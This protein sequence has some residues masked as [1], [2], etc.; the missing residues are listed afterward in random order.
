M[1]LDP[2]PIKLTQVDVTA[3]H[4][5]QD[6]APL[7]VVGGLP[8]ATTLTAGG[9]KKLPAQ[10]NSVA[11]DVAGLLADFNALLAKLRTA[12]ILS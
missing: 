7:V 4:S 11:T 9:V 1:A 6:P 2:A 8:A 5:A 10:A 12:G 3:Y